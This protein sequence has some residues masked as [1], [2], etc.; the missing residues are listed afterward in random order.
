MGTHS[1][2]EHHITHHKHKDNDGHIFGS[3]HADFTEIL[4]RIF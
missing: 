2:L 4:R 1:S 3:L